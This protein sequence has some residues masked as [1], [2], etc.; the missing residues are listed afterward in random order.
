M[1]VYLRTSRLTRRLFGLFACGLLTTLVAC[2]TGIP[3]EE[4]PGKSLT[5]LNGTVTN[6]SNLTL[7]SGVRIAI[8][9]RNFSR[10][11][12]ADYFQISQEFQVKTEFPFQFKY[13]INKLPPQ[14]AMSSRTEDICLDANPTGDDEDCKNTKSYQYKYVLG[15]IVVYE[16]KNGNGKLDLLNT[17]NDKVIDRVLGVPANTMLAYIEGDAPPIKT[18]DNSQLTKGFQLI[19]LQADA[20]TGFG[21]QHAIDKVLSKDTK[22]DIK[23][24]KT[25]ELS[26]YICEVPPFEDEQKILKELKEDDLTCSLDGRSYQWKYCAQDSFEVLCSYNNGCITGG[27]ALNEGQTAPSDWPCKI[28]TQV[29]SQNLKTDQKECSGSPYEPEEKKKERGEFSVDGKQIKIMYYKSHFRCAQKVHMKY[30]KKGNKIT[31][32]AQP[33]DMDPDPV[34]SCDCLYDLSATTP[35]LASGTYEVELL[36]RWDNISKAQTVSI[37]KETITIP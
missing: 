5:V 4:Y 7:S 27:K 20:R 28:D 25:P 26:R 18:Q 22:L 35:A 33:I 23:L 34:A 36:R 37:K 16:D 17:Q 14:Q 12:I 31:I 10:G 30:S 1:F 19:Q 2:G 3:T 8:V 6:P 11:N 15:S 13:D 24:T 9:W 29:T 21:L 32:T